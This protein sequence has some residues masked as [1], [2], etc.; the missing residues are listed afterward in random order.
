VGQSA[1][2]QRRGKVGVVVLSGFSSVRFPDSIL[3]GRCCNTIGKQGI[4]ADLLIDQPHCG[5]GTRPVV[6]GGAEDMLE[7]GPVTAK[8]CVLATR[9]NAP[10]PHFES[11]QLADLGTSIQR[12]IAA[13]ARRKL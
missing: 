5:Q 6:R 10:F 4:D 9:E 1:G 3:H 12:Q 11:E 13:L 7:L 8:L 2:V